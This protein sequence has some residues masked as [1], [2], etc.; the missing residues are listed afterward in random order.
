[1]SD[2]LMGDEVY[3]PDRS[4]VQDDAGLMD[5]EDTLNDR[6]INPALDEG[7]SPPEKPM[8]VNRFG[9]TASE[10]RRGESLEQ[11]LSEEEPDVSEPPGNGIGD[12]PG[13]DGEPL[14][15]DE[16]GDTRTGRLVGS[17]EGYPHGF[18]Q[19]DD[20]IAED[21]GISGGAAS[22]EE[23]AVHTIPEPEEPENPENPG[24]PGNPGEPPR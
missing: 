2:E 8:E 3:Q 15:E 23:A 9:T 13:G 21:V 18:G 5:P 11:R 6:G 16:V 12:L 1:M 14:R 4:E 24:N 10:Q 22:A 19:Q 20:M 7:Y 17:D